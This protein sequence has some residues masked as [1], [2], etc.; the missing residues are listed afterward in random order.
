M[1]RGKKITRRVMTE[2]IKDCFRS[3]RVVVKVATT[4]PFLEKSLEKY[5]PFKRELFFHQEVMPK[6]EDLLISIDDKAELT[7]K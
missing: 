3:Q 4:K 6:I 1:K 7:K 2:S 5:D